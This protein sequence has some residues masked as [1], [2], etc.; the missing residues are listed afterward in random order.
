MTICS[1][2]A[3]MQSNLRHTMHH[4]YNNCNHRRLF[5]V[6]T[7]YGKCKQCVSSY[8]NNGLI[9][10]FACP[11]VLLFPTHSPPPPPQQQQHCFASSLISI[12]T[13]SNGIQPFTF[14]FYNPS[15]VVKVPNFCINS[16]CKHTRYMINLQQ[17]TFERRIQRSYLDCLSPF[18]D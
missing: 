18:Q 3:R 5:T 9:G 13:T 11:R 14:H 7:R 8:V 6:Q 2:L 15:A 12:L 4:I 17:S 16:K 10:G 1:Q